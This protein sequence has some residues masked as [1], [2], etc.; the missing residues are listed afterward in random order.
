MNAHFLKYYLL[1]IIFCSLFCLSFAD[2]SA[3]NISVK[4]FRL[5]ETDLTANTAG[6]M[7]RDQNNEVAALIKIVTTET[8]FSFEGSSLGFVATKQTPGEIWLYVPRK[9]RKVTIKHATLGVLR[10]YYYP[11]SIEAGR[12]YEMVLV[13]GR[14]TTVVQEDAGGQYVAMTVSPTNAEVYID[15]TLVES[16]GGVLSKLLKYGKHTYRISAPLYEPE[17]GQFEITSQGR[18]DLQVSLRPAYGQLQITSEPSGAQVYIDGDYK[19]AGTTPFTTERLPKGSHTLQ[20]KL[21]SYKPLTEKV[22]ISGDGSVQTKAVALAPNF[23]EV[24][25]SVPDEAEIFINE[26][27]KGTGKWSGR[28]NTGMYT[29]E[30]RKVSHYP[31][32]RTVEVK[33]GENQ[34][35]VL[36][37][38]VPRYGSININTQPIGATVSVDGRVLGESPNIFKDVLIGTHTLAVSKEGYATKTSTITV[39]EGKITP[40]DLQLENGGSVVI[41]SNVTNARV[42]IDGQFKGIAPYTYSD[43]AGRYQVTVKAD[44]YNDVTQ[45]VVIAAGQTNSETITPMPITG[46]VQIYAYP[47]QTKIYIDGKYV[48]DAPYR[49]VGTPGKYTV[50]AIAYGYKSKTQEINIAAGDDSFTSIS[51]KAKRK[52]LMDYYDAGDLFSLGGGWDI[53][54]TDKCS[55]GGYLSFKMGQES[56]TWLTA[57][58]N[59][60]GYKMGKNRGG[61]FFKEE[62]DPEIDEIDSENSLTTY[63]QIPLSLALRLRLGGGDWGAMY[64]GAQGSYNFN[65]GDNVDLGIVNS[66]NYSIGGQIGFCAKRIFDFNLFFTYD[67]KPAYN[68]EY[69]YG[70]MPDFY[71]TYVDHLNK[72]WRFGTSMVIYIPFSNER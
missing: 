48:G 53:L 59:I 69:I 50:T 62:G 49:F 56:F 9:S 71:N 17:M 46:A 41:R 29:I 11:L 8:G 67:L 43:G 14:V 2:L 39:E 1:A 4:S 25:V 37:S 57:V 34:Q 19:P 68:Q 18:T 32:K 15:E 60:G 38:P 64:I 16:A 70:N 58:V 13:T 27:S 5:L 22:V 28:L 55:M 72:R 36:Q 45:T 35:I 51:L 6:T 63:T 10:D 65:M 54:W 7:K 33:A 23:A 3:Q 42:Y 24:S 12:T 61:K 66:R 44:G 52:R 31:T 47:S 21:G 26:E 40:V 30:A 20:F